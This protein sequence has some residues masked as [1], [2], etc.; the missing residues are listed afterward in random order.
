MSEFT[1]FARS[2]RV[3][4]MAGVILAAMEEARRLYPEDVEQQILYVRNAV[5]AAQQTK[6]DKSADQ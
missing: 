6:T 2:Q 1:S 3:P 5:Q 4:G